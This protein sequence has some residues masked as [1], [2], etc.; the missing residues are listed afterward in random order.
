VRDDEVLPWGQ[1]DLPCAIAL[2][3]MARVGLLAD[4]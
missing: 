3:Q 4:L 1:A 2:C